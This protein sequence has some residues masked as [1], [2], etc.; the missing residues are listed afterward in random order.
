[1][2]EA[3]IYIFLSLIIIS[4]EIIAYH[5]DQWIVSEENVIIKKQLVTG[6]LYNYD[7]VHCQGRN[8]SL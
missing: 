3:S 1:M 8:I 5:I 6:E 4:I 7:T 2:S